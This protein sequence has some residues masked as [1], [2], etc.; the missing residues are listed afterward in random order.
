MSTV[1]WVAAA[2]ALAACSAGDPAEQK[3]FDEC[4]AAAVSQYPSTCKPGELCVDQAQIQGMGNSMESCM[5]SKN[6]MY[7][8]RKPGCILPEQWNANFFW[9]KNNASCYSAP[10]AK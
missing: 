5:I 6:Y 10:T 1:A 9:L 4:H 7:D 3:A 2:L 8:E